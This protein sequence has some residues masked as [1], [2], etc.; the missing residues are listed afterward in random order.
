MLGRPPGWEGRAGGRNRRWEE[1]GDLLPSPCVLSIPA[2]G[3][4]VGELPH[5]DRATG[6]S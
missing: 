2:K 4:R 6:N 3:T 5:G 1:A